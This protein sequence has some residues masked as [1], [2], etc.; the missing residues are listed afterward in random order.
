[1]K[2]R[3][4]F[5]GI[6]VSE[7]SLEVAVRPTGK[8]WN[9]PND[10]A[11]I[12]KLTADLK[13]VKP[14]LV[15]LEASG[16]LQVPVA[17][18]LNVARVSVAVVNPR[19]VRDFARATGKLAKTDALDAQVLA[20]FAEAVRPEPR[21]LPD[22][23]TQTLSA[24]MARRRQ[25]VEMITAEK[26]RL[27]TTLLPLRPGVRAHIE[28]LQRQLAELDGQLRQALRKSPVWREKD[29]LLRSVPGVGPTTSLTLLAHFPELGTLGRQ[30]AAALLGVAPLNRDSGKFHGKR[31]IWG[32]RGKVRAPLYMAAVSA[33]RCNP[34]IRAFYRRLLAAGKPKKVALTACIRKLIT[35]LNAIIKHSKPWAF[36]CLQTV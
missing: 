1:M 17:A 5:V 31:Q 8:E 19:Q 18:A 26:N 30:E 28:W 36:P 13:R 6:D 16:G 2:D 22:V 4:I 3:S 10:A 7:D 11:G 21:P 12:K 27:R 34:M 35:V 14:T 33:T 29:K 15:V 25:L 9:V 20:H 23:E 32:G 24:L